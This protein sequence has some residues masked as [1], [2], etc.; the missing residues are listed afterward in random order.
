ML[1]QVDV[2]DVMVLP[3]AQILFSAN[4]YVSLNVICNTVSLSNE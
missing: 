1:V 3:A 2:S 4:D